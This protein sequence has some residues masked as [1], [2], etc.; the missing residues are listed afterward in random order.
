[1]DKKSDILTKLG[2]DS[3]FKVPE[4]YFADF[5]D[6]MANSLPERELPKVIKPT[7]WMRI[8]PY[9]YMAAMFAGVWCMLYLFQDLSK[10]SGATS[11]D[12]QFA[13]AM[14]DPQMWNEL[15]K[16]GQ[17]SDADLMD[18]MNDSNMEFDTTVN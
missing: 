8:R 7:R 2:K 14:S 15:E 4:G 11:T 9:V 3:G 5:A 10:R 18:L 13:E 1:M 6:K 16:S 17:V 12:G